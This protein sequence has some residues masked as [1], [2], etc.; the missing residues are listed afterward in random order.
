M[1]KRSELSVLWREGMF[2]SP[3]HFQAF[4]REVESRVQSGDSVARP[5]GFGALEL[6]IDAE[7]LA[8]DVFR[9][10]TA[11]VL[12][13]DGKLASFP[14]NANVAPR[15]FTEHLTGADLM[16]WLGIP[17][18]QDNQPQIGNGTDRNYRYEVEVRGVHD[19]NERDAKKE[20]E[21]R[22]LRGHVFFGDEDRSG[23]ETLPIARLVRRGQPEAVTLVC[24]DYVVPVLACGASTALENG[25]RETAERARAQARDLAAHLPST[26]LL[27]SADKG[28]DLA[29]LVKLQAVNQSVAGLEQVASQP[30]LHPFDAYLELVRTVGNL[31]LFADD[32]VLPE[33]P[34]YDHGRLNDC[35]SKVFAEVRRLLAAEVAVPYDTMRFDE[36]PAREGIFTSAIPAEWLEADPIFYLGVEMNQPQEAAAE[37]VAAG[38]K[39]LAESDL[40]NVLQGVLPGIGLESVRIAP[41]SF[42]K[43]EGLHYFRVE[44]EGA[45]RDLWLRVLADRKVV[46][47]SALG[48]I[49]EVK[50]GIYVELRG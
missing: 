2:L 23:F 27:S 7:A 32:R 1:T 28:A 4:Q 43:R 29:G 25:L 44:T 37:L 8:R 26:S 31:A 24:P 42:P 50:C 11:T 18:A 41:P 21:F 40:E 9:I 45:S 34:K 38:V 39:M 33:L 48:A 12:F 14:K 10:E 16:V 22:A 13:R 3:Q 19:E 15:E 17:A 47:L 35:F 46:I 20:I 5:G 30:D 36:D 6:T 49:E